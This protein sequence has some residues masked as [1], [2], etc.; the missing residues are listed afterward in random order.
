MVTY[1]IHNKH[2]KTTNYTKRYMIATGRTLDTNIQHLHDERNIPLLHKHLKS[3]A[4]QIIQTSQHTTS[5]LKTN[6]TEV[7][8]SAAL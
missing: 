2:Y 7:L 6:L 5:Y 4:S 8:R 3:H 1:Y